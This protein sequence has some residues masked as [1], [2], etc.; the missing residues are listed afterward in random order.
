MYAHKHTTY[1]GFYFC[2]CLV[3]NVSWLTDPLQ[4]YPTNLQM[5]FIGVFE[6]FGILDTAINYNITG[7]FVITLKLYPHNAYIYKIHLMSPRETS[8]QVIST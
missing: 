2:F 8:Q 4:A 3:S 1:V 6:G 5:L 7:I